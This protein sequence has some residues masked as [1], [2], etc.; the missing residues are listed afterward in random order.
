MPRT[1]ENLNN[2]AKCAVTSRTPRRN[3]GKSIFQ[4]F[5]QIKRFAFHLLERIKYK[6]NVTKFGLTDNSRTF[7]LFKTKRTRHITDDRWHLFCYFDCY[8]LKNKGYSS[9]CCCL[10][11]IVS[12]FGHEREENSPFLFIQIS[13]A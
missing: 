10:S 3:E 11:R 8:Y 2:G 5:F 9:L 13:L 12:S 4:D 1:S 6:K 7:V